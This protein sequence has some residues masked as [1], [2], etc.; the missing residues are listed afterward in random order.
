METINAPKSFYRHPWFVTMG[1]IA[2]LVLWMGL[3]SDTSERKPTRSYQAEIEQAVKKKLD[4]PERALFIKDAS[5]RTFKNNNYK[6]VA[7]GNVLTENTG[8]DK[9]KL[10]YQV[11]FRVKGSGDVA[12][13]ERIVVI[14]DRLWH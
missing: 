10:Y 5:V 12:G 1:V 4:H 7:S 8:G 13:V 11:Q 6:M 9:L 3:G 2:G 14:E